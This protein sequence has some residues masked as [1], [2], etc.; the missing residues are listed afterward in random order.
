MAAKQN[1]NK[2]GKYTDLISNESNRAQGWM[3]ACF[4]LLA[5]LMYLGYL[6]HSTIQNMPVRLVPMDYHTNKGITE[7]TANGKKNQEYIELIATSDA[8]LFTEFRPEDAVVKTQKLLNRFEPSLYA[9]NKAS[10]L[11]QAASNK[12]E[13]V[14]QWYQVEYTK[15]RDGNEVLIYGFMKRWEGS[16]ITFEGRVNF[17]ITYRYLNGIPYIANYQRFDDEKKIVTKLNEFASEE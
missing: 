9:T 10:L 17:A 8:N 7:V 4:I 14:T 11:D 3:F 15:S 12:E 13:Q 2:R 5:F 6:L 1:E 16:E